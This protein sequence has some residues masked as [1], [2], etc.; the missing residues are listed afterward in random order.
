MHWRTIGHVLG[1]LALLLGAFMT[2]PLL[3]ALVNGTAPG[4]FL[5]SAALA[6]VVGVALGGGP[7]SVRRAPR[8]VRCNV[9]R[10]RERA[11]LP[12]GAQ[13]G[14]QAEAL[15]PAE[16]AAGDELRVRDAFV[17][18]TFGWLLAGVLGAVPFVLA[19][20]LGPVDAFFES[21]SGFTTTGATVLQ[22]IEGLPR[23]LLLWRSMLQWLGGMGI[24]VLFVS[25]V[26]RPSVGGAHLFRAEFP[27][28]IPEKLL[29]RITATA[30]LL[31]SLYTV[32]T[33]VA[34]LAYWAAGL[35]LFDAINHA[36]TTLSTGG[37]STHT[38]GVWENPWAEGAAIL[39]MFLGGTSFVLQHRL[40]RLRDWGALRH[41]AEFWAYLAVAALAMLLVAVSLVRSGLYGDAAT[42]LRKAAFQVVSLLSTTGYTSADY[43]AWPPLAA[44]VL[45]TVMFIGGM[46]GSTGGGPKVFR[47]L[48]MFKQVGSETVRLL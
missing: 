28:P 20:V 23:G 33:L 8:W 31:W 10:W 3:L 26:Q 29:P 37:F 46:T 44:A 25:V 15:E 40:Y 34:V 1:N 12:A 2:L 38:A 7:A 5:A 9:R 39:F 30:R 4:T 45:F 41:A 27:G 24:I 19:G 43:G 14:P 21:V 16:A 48:V 42:A 47:W 35:T 18:V 6:A 13:N 22:R 36:F 17:I 11:G 32:V